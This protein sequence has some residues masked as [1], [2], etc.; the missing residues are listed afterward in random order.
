MEKKKYSKIVFA[1]NRVNYSFDF[2]LKL[3]Y[4]CHLKIHAFHRLVAL[5]VIVT[6]FKG[7]RCALVWHNTMV[8]R[9]IAGLSAQLAQNVRPI[10]LASISNA[11][12]LVQVFA[13]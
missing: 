7:I 11:S 2:V 5:I 12:I 8:R 6:S 1:I 4:L 3:I 13:A 10:N 9:P